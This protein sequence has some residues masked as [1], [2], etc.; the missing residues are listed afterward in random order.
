MKVCTDSCLFG[1]WAAKKISET[2]NTP[3]NIL[4]IG[5][6]TGLLSLMLAQKSEAKMD[7][8]EIDKNAFEQTQENFAASPWKYRLRAFHHDFAKMPFDLKYD[9][10]ICNPPFFEND[11]ISSSK[12]KNLAKHHDGLTLKTLASQINTHLTDSGK[13]AILL[14]FHRMGYFKKIAFENKFFTEEEVFIK[15]TPVHNYFRGIQLFTKNSATKAIEDTIII[16]D[17]SNH[18]S[19]KFSELLKDY[20]LKVPSQM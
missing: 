15:Q 6:G 16:K 18:Y 2:T 10:I 1:A 17:S 20:Y 14:P 19:A 4:D 3:K 9:F 12:T 7:A 8:I 11:L 13:F 5:A